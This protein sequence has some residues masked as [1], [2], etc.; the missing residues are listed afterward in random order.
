M[1]IA[2]VSCG[3]D[4]VAMIQYL[5]AIGTK[6][7]VCVYSNTG[8]AAPDWEERVEKFKNWVESLGYKFQEIQGVYNFHSICVHKKFIA[9]KFAR[10]CTQWLKQIPFLEYLDAIDQNCEATIYLGLRREESKRRA[11]IELKIENSEHMGGRTQMHP[12]YL[13]TKKERDKLIKETP[14]TLLQHRSRECFPCIFAS[15]RDLRDLS[16]DL[17]SINKVKSLEE[18]VSRHIGQQA[19]FF[20]PSQFADAIGIDEVVKVVKHGRKQFR[21]EQAG[22]EKFCESGFCG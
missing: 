9:H 17:V 22:Q 8:W 21:L 1:N 13:H 11:N 14:L 19:C 15:A 20:N 16:E 7:V 5:H 12:L 10:F 6:D 2:S 3:N 18:E 4:S